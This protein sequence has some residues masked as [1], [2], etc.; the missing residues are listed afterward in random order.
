MTSAGRLEYWFKVVDFLQQNWAL[1]DINDDM[2]ATVL[3]IDDASGVFDEMPFS[4]DNEARQ[5]L[6]RNGF[7]LLSEDAEAQ[8]FISP[9]R[10]PFHERRRPIYSSGEYWKS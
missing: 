4:S 2:S 7:K 3:F 9:P 6:R 5:G 10:P 8:G 1:I